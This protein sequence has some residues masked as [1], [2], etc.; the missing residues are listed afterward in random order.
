MRWKCPIRA[1]ALCKTLDNDKSKRDHISQVRALPF[2]DLNDIQNSIHHFMSEQ[3]K[4][5]I[6]KF[7]HFSVS[8]CDNIRIFTSHA[9]YYEQALG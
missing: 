2:Q 6:P 9:V 7:V 1:R 3:N 8:A 4:T 5:A